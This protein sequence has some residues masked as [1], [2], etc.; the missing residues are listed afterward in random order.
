VT[1]QPAGD[2]G[3]QGR[4]S[5]GIG[6]VMIAAWENQAAIASIA[7]ALSQLRDGSGGNPKPHELPNGVTILVPSWQDMALDGKCFEGVGLATDLEVTVNPKDLTRKDPILERALALL[8]GEAEVTA[9]ERGGAFP[10]CAS[11]L[12]PR[13]G[14]SWG[15]RYCGY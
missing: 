13:L 15:S 2:N 11:P 7:T 5:D 9:C 6:Y 4:T 12:R 3:V 8:R 1:V 14:L 10:R